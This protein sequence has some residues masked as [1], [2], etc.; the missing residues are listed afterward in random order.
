MKKRVSI[1][2]ALLIPTLAACESPFDLSMP[3]PH[4]ECW[5]SMGCPGSADW[6]KDLP[7]IPIPPTP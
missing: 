7:T 1:L 4:A 5:G 3:A 6:P 2:I